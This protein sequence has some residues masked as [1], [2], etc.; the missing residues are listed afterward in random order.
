MREG[1]EFVGVAAMLAHDDFRFKGL[2]ELRHHGVECPQ[3]PGV[4]RPRRQCDVDGCA[5]RVLA[6]DLVGESRSWEQREAAFVQ[7]NRQDPRVVPEDAL[8]AVAVV[9]IDVDVRDPADTAVEQPLHGECGVVIDAEAAGT[10]TGGVMHAA[11]EVDGAD[12][13]LGQD[14][15]GREQRPSGKPGAGFVHSGKSGIILGA[16]TA[17]GVRR[18]RVFACTPHCG[19][20]FGTVHCLEFD[21]GRD[22]GRLDGHML[23]VEESERRCEPGRQFQ[24]R[25]GH[26]MRGT[27]IVCGHGGVPRHRRWQRGRTE[28]CP[29]SHQ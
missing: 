21:V 26:R 29:G 7:G 28:A 6:A 25:G 23:Q 17:F 11:A 3:P 10:P 1:I 18:R 14:R 13:G 16:E 22:L 20:I 8:G 2:H 24:P 19:D 15:L 9:G 4:A 12:R 27:E 5:E